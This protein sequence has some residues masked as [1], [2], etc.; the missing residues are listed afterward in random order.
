MLIGLVR[1]GFLRCFCNTCSVNSAIPGRHI[2]KKPMKKGSKKPK[3]KQPKKARYH[4]T[5]ATEIRC[6]EK[7]RGGMCYEVILAQ[8]CG[9]KPEPQAPVSPRP[10]SCTHEE[11]QQKLQQAEERRKT[12]EASRV[13]MTERMS[14]LEEASRKRDEI[15]AAF[16]T[17]TQKDL[18]SKLDQ[19]QNN[20]EAYLNGL[21]AKVHDHLSNVEAVAKKSETDRE[22]LRVNIEA[23]MKNAE[24]KRDENL[25]TMLSK[26]KEHD[27][28]LRQ[29]RLG[30]DDAVKTLEK[31]IQ[32]KLNIAEA[33]RETEIM[34]KLETLREHDRRAELVRAN[35]ERLMA[36]EK[37]ETASSG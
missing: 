5:T 28:H 31:N 17:S 4:A 15:N 13:K 12:V 35:K 36:A 21:K 34:K 16:I 10:K 32:S 6:E 20:R 22:D 19:S 30:H 24:E 27:D 11:I 2:H 8:P 37:H 3:C 9:D 25:S 18:D 29:V 26:L 23:K 33:K 1:D 7:S 14:K